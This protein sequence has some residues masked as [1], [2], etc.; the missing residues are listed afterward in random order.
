MNIKAIGTLS[1]LFIRGSYILKSNFQKSEVTTGIEFL[2]K[3]KQ[4]LA[5]IYFL[6]IGPF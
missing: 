1:Q 4:P 3:M 6:R 5:K 2:K